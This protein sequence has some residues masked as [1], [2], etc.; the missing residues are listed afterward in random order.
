MLEIALVSLIYMMY[1]QLTVIAMINSSEQSSPLIQIRAEWH[2]DEACWIATNALTGE[3]IAEAP[4]LAEIE[5]QVS[6]W[7]NSGDESPFHFMPAHGQGRF[8]MH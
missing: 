5:F 4:T 3:G 1:Q 6:I 2:A 7:A 8:M